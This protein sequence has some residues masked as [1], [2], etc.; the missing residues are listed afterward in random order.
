M[1]HKVKGLSLNS[2]AISFDLKKKKKKPL[3]LEQMYV[4]LSRAAGIKILN[5]VGAYSRNAL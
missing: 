1:V 5:L 4:A 2:A 3:N